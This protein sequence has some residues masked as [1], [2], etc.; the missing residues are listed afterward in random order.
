[1]A[2]NT[3]QIEALDT[4][5][6]KDGK[7][8]SMGEET[9]AD[10]LFPPSPS[11]VYGA[12]RTAFFSENIDA[13]STA[14]TENDPTKKLVINKI[15]FKKVENNF[16]FPIPLDLVKYKDDI[17]NNCF[18]E[19][20][21][22]KIDFDK[23]ISNYPLENLS[24][25]SDIVE[26]ITGFIND[27]ELNCYIKNKKNNY[28]YEE[29]DS[30]IITEPKIGIKRNK[31]TLTTEEGNLYRIGQIRLQKNINDIA[32]KIIVEFSF[33]DYKIS[34]KY[35]KLG[36]ES[37]ISTISECEAFNFAEPEKF[38]KYFKL[39]FLTPAI[40]KNGWIPNELKQNNE[41]ELK[42]IKL[43]LLK[44]FVGKP[45]LIGGYDLKS[46]KGKNGYPKPMYKAIPW[47]SIYYFE[48]LDDSKYEDIIE[49][50]HLKN[51][52]D[53]YSEQGFGNTIVCNLKF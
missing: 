51:I 4:L 45:I 27:Y 50:F 3:I 19:Q 46:S 21:N 33:G 12:L 41:L 40:F 44:A 36:A 24:I 16:W 31:E 2:Y 38:D 48:I 35:L 34:S 22:F 20:T 29:I 18:C 53:F 7:P 49:K 47:G 6:F 17:S 9:W 13:F 8:F 43:K 10:G 14:N 26:N 11:T 52:S 39:L 15:Y 5:F 37:K 25:S 23:I 32:L 30:F 1:M 28:T 42:G